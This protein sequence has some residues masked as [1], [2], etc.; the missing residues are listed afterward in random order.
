MGRCAAAQGVCG[1]DEEDRG[2]LSHRFELL[3]AAMLLMSR[4]SRLEE[5]G[6][7][8]T[9]RACR[10]SESRSFRSWHKHVAHATRCSAL[11]STMARFTVTGSS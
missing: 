1:G 3:F 6:G 9:S 4:E 11:E 10:P 5:S 2:W 7:T 8:W